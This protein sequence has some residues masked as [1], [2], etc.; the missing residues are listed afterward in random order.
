MKEAS[1]RLK[2]FID[3][4]QPKGWYKFMLESILQKWEEEESE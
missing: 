2:A 4:T 1:E 3:K